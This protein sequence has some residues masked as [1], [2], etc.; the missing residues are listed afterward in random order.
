M[1]APSGTMRW[2]PYSITETGTLTVSSSHTLFPARRLY[3]RDFSGPW[4]S[5]STAA[6][7]FKV[8]QAGTIRPVDTLI[9]P[10]NN[11][12]SIVSHWAFSDDDISYTAVETFTP[13]SPNTTIARTIDTT[14]ISAR[15]WRVM[16]VSPAIVQRA[17]ELY[18]G[19]RQGLEIRIQEESNVTVDANAERLFSPSRAIWVVDRG[20]PVRTY[21]RRVAVLPTSTSTWGAES[22]ID[23]ILADLSHGKKKFWMYDERDILRPVVFANSYRRSPLV[24]GSV[25]GLEVELVEVPL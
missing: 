5:N 21:Q 6:V 12:A 8:D 22:I 24:P 3:D 23:T 2:V 4:L 7:T 25:F 15:Y 9:I 11:L 17:A 13:T 10:R 16:T 18:L 19:Q 14:L 20:S 1:A